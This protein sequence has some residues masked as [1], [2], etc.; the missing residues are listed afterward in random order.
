VCY[1]CHAFSLSHNIIY[2]RR[3]LISWVRFPRVSISPH[4]SWTYIFLFSLCV[5]TFARSGP[6]EGSRR[7]HITYHA[8]PVKKSA[9]KCGKCCVVTVRLVRQHSLHVSRSLAL[10]LVLSISNHQTR[11]TGYY[12]EQFKKL[13]YWITYSLYK[14]EWQIIDNIIYIKKKTIF[15]FYNNYYK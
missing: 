11:N 6:A 15:Y 9:C 7:R 13:D 14:L 1:T 4:T 5:S 12:G 3:G 8:V 2:L 10:P